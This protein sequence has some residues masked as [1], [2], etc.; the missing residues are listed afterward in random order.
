MAKVKEP[1][2]LIILAYSLGELPF[3]R[4]DKFVGLIKFKFYIGTPCTKS[5][6]TASGS[7]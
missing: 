5:R 6:P 2:N 1:I 3:E 4:P 7:V